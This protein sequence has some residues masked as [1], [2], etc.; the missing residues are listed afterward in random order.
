MVTHI[1]A[2][3]VPTRLTAHAPDLFA[4][5]QLISTVIGDVFREKAL[6]IMAEN[7]VQV[8]DNASHREDI[9]GNKDLP[10]LFQAYLLWDTTHNPTPL[11]KSMLPFEIVFAEVSDADGLRRL[12]YPITPE[13]RYTDA[14]L[15]MEIEGR[16]LFKTH[17]GSDWKAAMRSTDPRS[18]NSLRHLP[19]WVLPSTGEDVLREVRLQPDLDLNNY[20]T[21]ERRLRSAL[22]TSVDVTSLK[23]AQGL[24]SRARASYL[25]QATTAF[26]DSDEGRATSRPEPLP[27]ELYVSVSELPPVFVP[28]P[29]ATA[30]VI[31]LFNDTVARES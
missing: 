16:P 12:V 26:L 10:L 8:M 30:A 24:N 2:G 17:P 29:E 27:V 23:S 20:V 6:I 3:P 7:T 5:T 9:R 1:N 11:S 19:R 31:E 25:R 28:D 21:P 22:R 18:D 4:M 15:A 14:L 13:R